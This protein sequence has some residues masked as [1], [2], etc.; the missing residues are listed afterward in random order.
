MYVLMKD[1]LLLF[2]FYRKH[3]FDKKIIFP[4]ICAVLML[5]LFRKKSTFHQLFHMSLTT[6][7]KTLLTFKLVS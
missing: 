2:C 7:F 3:V 4:N 1:H 5:E 6:V